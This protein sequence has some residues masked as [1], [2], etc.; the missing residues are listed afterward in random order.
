MSRR[1]CGSKVPAHR[2]QRSYAEV[3]DGCKSASAIRALGQRANGSVIEIA[4]IK[5]NELLQT[6]MIEQSDVALSK[7]EKPAL[8]KFP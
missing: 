2:S 8:T 3:S 6:G 5:P 7:F 1:A 4:P